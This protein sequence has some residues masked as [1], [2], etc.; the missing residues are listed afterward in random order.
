MTDSRQFAI[1]QHPL[2]PALRMG[3]Q[4]LPT[5][6]P[7]TLL[8]HVHN[9][10]VFL[11]KMRDGHGRHQISFAKQRQLLGQFAV[12]DCQSQV[13]CHGDDLVVKVQIQDVELIDISFI[14]CFHLVGELAQVAKLFR[15][16]AL[17]Q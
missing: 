13:A 6:E 3:I 5:T 9:G 11:R 10:A 16:D 8:Q 15:V 1:A 2:P 14:N 4:C 7:I 17:G 12:C